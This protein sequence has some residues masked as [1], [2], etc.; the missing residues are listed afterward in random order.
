MRKEDIYGQWETALLVYGAQD[1][2]ETQGHWDSDG[3]EGKQS[4]GLKR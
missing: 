3:A 2:T 1:K 4:L